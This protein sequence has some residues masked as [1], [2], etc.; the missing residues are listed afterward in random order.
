MYM[1]TFYVV[2]FEVGFFYVDTNLQFAKRPEVNK[3]LKK[4]RTATDQ[5][6]CNN[7]CSTDFKGSIVNKRI[8]ELLI[9]V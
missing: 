8:K 6:G 5:H 1:Y 3:N 7:P 9:F 2:S 4:I